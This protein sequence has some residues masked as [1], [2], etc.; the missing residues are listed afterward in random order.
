MS[1]KYI[2]LQV[3]ILLLLE[4]YASGLSVGSNTAPSRQAFVTF[5]AVD[6]TNT[7]LGFAAFEAGFALQS[8]SAT[9]TYN[10]FYPVSQTIDMRGGQL[11]LSKDLIFDKTV[12]MI[13]SARIFG[14]SNSIT[15]GKST[16]DLYLSPSITFD[17]STLV[18]N[19]NTRI[20]APMRFRNSCKINAMGKRLTLQGNAEITVWPGGNLIIEN[21]EIWGVKKNNI[22]NLTDRGALTFRNTILVLS[23]NFTFSRGSFAIDDQVTI[24]GT[25]TFI[26]TTAATSTI[27]SLSTLSLEQGLTFSYQPSRPNSTL[28]FMSDPT[29]SMYLNGCTLYS[30]RTGLQLST[31]TITI[32][33]YV[34]FTSE[35][36]SL[37]EAMIISPDLSVK[38]R[39][40]GFVDL[41][42]LIRYG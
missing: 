10:G 5:P 23:E 16:T 27:L 36:R 13:S 18:F 29:S 8:A 41:H 24:T 4:F 6:T 20:Q 3:P 17:T 2:S 14:R 11:W 9:C 12:N 34:T 22:R 1:S 32:D 33:N 40:K 37:S 7:I 19:S 26:Y 42:G 25:S 30:S 15:F 31:G 38:I 35:A 28:I 39:G 21:A